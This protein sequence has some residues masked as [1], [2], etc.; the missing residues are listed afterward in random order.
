[1]R[2][3][4][5]LRSSG[6]RPRT[7][8]GLR[9]CAL[10]R[11]GKQSSPMSQSGAAAGHRPSS[12][13]SLASPCALCGAGRMRGTATGANHAVRQRP[14][15]WSANGRHTKK[16]ARALEFCREACAREARASKSTR[17]HVLLVYLVPLRVQQQPSMQVIFVHCVW[18]DFT[19]VRSRSRH[20]HS[21]NDKCVWYGLCAHTR[22]RPTPHTLTL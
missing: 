12:N 5:R 20:I 22:P 10:L 8:S 9:R 6:R 1:M 17:A 11:W 16:R 13:R 15:P 14:C 19:C 18:R 21:R 4:A 7:T 3:L 2:G